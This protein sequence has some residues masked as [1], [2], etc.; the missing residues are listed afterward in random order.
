[1]LSRYGGLTQREIAPLLGVRTGK[2]ASV[3]LSRLAIAIEKDRRLARQVADIEK[4]LKNESESTN[5]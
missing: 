2:A 5:A 3:Q 4:D 1:M